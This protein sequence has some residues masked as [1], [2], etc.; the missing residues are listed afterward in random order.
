L[1]RRR[2]PDSLAAAGYDRDLAVE[3]EFYADRPPRIERRL[4]RRSY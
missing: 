3:V 1:E 4:E 2:A